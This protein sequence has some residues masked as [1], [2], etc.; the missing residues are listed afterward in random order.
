[1]VRNALMALLDRR[2]N[3]PPLTSSGVQPRDALMGDFTQ[4]ECTWTFKSPIFRTG[5][6]ALE[7]KLGSPCAWN[8]LSVT[9]NAWGSSDAVHGSP[10]HLGTMNGIEDIPCGRWRRT[11][12]QTQKLQQVSEG[13]VDR[14]G[15]PW[16]RSQALSDTVD[17]GVRWSGKQ[18]LVGT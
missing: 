2:P 14:S 1:M 16:S 10:D 18:T 7:Y 4:T 8:S 13:V 12:P 17:G 6:S 11:A 9:A 5:R 3:L 15:R